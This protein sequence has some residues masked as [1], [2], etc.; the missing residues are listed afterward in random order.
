MEDDEDYD[1]DDD[2][3]AASF[4]IIMGVAFP[5]RLPELF[6]HDEDEIIPVSKEDP[7]LEAKLFLMLP[8]AVAVIQEYA[9]AV[10]DGMNSMRPDNYPAAPKPIKAEKIGR[11][12]PCPC[13]SGKKYKKC[14]G[15]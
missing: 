14:C 11:N 15:Q 10:R 3:I 5:E 4:S 6:D 12:D 8:Q 7:E 13:G 2:E 1:E 9:N